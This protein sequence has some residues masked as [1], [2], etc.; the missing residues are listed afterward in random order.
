MTS[1]TAPRYRIEGGKTCIDIRLKTAHQLFDGRDPAPFR[2][3]DL[4]ED[5]VDY[6]VGAFEELPGK[7]EV[8]IVF[9][10]AEAP[11][12]PIPT[13]TIREA[14]KAF[15]E[16][17]VGRLNRRLRQHLRTGQFALGGGLVILALFLSLAEMTSL[18]PEGTLRDILR[19]GLVIIG[20]V[21]MWRPLD[22]LLYDWLPLSR[23][24]KLFERIA[25]TEIEVTPAPAVPG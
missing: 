5:A 18:L 14:V 13:E 25:A 21:A 7:T 8:K 23:E 24:R 11:G 16:G 15:F 4:D 20:W 22:V 19:E 6:I 1:A 9:W 17:E 2:E 12:T 10:M 3:R